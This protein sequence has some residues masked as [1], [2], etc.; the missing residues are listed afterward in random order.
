MDKVINPHRGCTKSNSYYFKL[1]RTS[2]F[3]RSNWPLAISPFAKVIPYW[4]YR[5]L[6]ISLC[7]SSPAHLETHSHTNPYP[8]SRLVQPTVCTFPSKL[9]VVKCLCY[10]H[11]G[12]LYLSVKLIHTRHKVLPLSIWRLSN[13]LS[14]RV[15]SYQSSLIVES[16]IITLLPPTNYLDFANLVIPNSIIWH[17]SSA[18]AFAS[19]SQSTSTSTYPIR[20]IVRATPYFIALPHFLEIK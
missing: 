9:L 1:L 12:V 10:L 17:S 19:S 18:I 16:T 11:L 5:N 14:S 4:I 20:T 15:H 13:W 6:F 7:S 3:A 2:I 8:I